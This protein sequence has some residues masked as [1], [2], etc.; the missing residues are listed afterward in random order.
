MI[1]DS[2]KKI[3]RPAVSSL[4]YPNDY[5][6]LQ[7]EVR[8]HLKVKISGKNTFE[9]F[10]NEIST[11]KALIVPHAGYIYSGEIAA[12][13]Y[14]LLQKYPKY[15]KRVLI[16]GPSHYVSLNGATFPSADVFETPL[17]EIKIDKVMLEKMLLDFSYISVSDK[18]HSEE[19]SLEV[20]LPFLQEILNEFEFLPLIVGET[21][22]EQIVDIIEYFNEHQGTLIVISTDLS[23]FYDY[24][25]AIAKDART[26]KAIE[27]FESEKI[28]VDDACG[29]YPLRG[30]LA[31][32]KKNEWRINRLGICNSGD[33]GGERRRVVGYGAWVI[34][35]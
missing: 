1:L 21:E 30:V 10:S 35:T 33:T 22:T 5:E 11:I 25:T 20:Q 32:A 14:R 17:G 27:Y 18:A 9:N 6:E 16:M 15:F 24:Q 28:S 3:R 19:H 23:H 13:A 4:F 31:A 29:A 7:D 12:Y 34:T 26:A 2:T 8:K